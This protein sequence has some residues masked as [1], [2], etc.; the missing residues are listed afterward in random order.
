MSKKFSFDTFSKHNM[1]AGSS[2]A[3]R[4]AGE[5]TVI[6]LSKQQSD[7]VET[8]SEEDEYRL[9][10]DNNSGSFA[11]DWPSE[12]LEA[13]LRCNFQRCQGASALR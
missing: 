8:W 3:L 13:V 7:G 1:Y 6:N 10:V 12:G 9:I 5:L 2:K 4:Y 11:P